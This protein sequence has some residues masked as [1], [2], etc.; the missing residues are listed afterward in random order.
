M[1]VINITYAKFK[2]LEFV[3]KEIQLYFKGSKK[4]YKLKPNYNGTWVQENY[5]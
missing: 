4:R 1:Q 5:L 2:C 3:P